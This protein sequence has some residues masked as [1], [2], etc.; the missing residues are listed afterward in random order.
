MGRLSGRVALVTGGGRG[1][2]RSIALEFARQGAKVAVSS[3]TKQ[4]LDGV[5]AEIGKLGSEGLAVVCDALD[6]EA[7]KKMVAS[8]ISHFGRLDILVNNAGGV[9]YDKLEDIL[10]LSSDDRLF[11]DHLF[12]NLTSAYY[13]TR[14]ALSQMVK[15]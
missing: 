14:Y 7:I 10:S 8:V 11:E 1:I 9:Y 6:R 13:A 5:A 2:G 3:R 4:E 15:Q 12:F